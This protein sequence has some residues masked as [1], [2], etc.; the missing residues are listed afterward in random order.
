MQSVIVYWMKKQ[1]YNVKGKIGRI[2][3]QKIQGWAFIPD[4]NESLELSLVINEKIVLK[5]TANL[6]NRWTK[7]NNIHPT[8]YCGF[9]FSL[10][11]FVLTSQDNV[12]VFFKDYQ[13]RKPKAVTVQNYPERSSDNLYFFIH[14]PKTAGTTFRIMLEQQ[15]SKETFFPNK[16]DL[17]ANNGLYP[18][19]RKLLDEYGDKMATS[20][21][22]AGHYPFVVGRAFDRKVKFLTFLRPPVERTISNIYH[23]QRYNKRVKGCSFEEIIRQVPN[24]MDNLQTRFFCDKFSEPSAQFYIGKP[25]SR[26]QLEEAKENLKRCDF[27]GI[28]EA[29]EDSVDLLEK[30]FNWQLGKRLKKNVTPRKRKVLPKKLLEQITELNQLDIELYEYGKQLFRQRRQETK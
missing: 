17:K 3:R 14:I 11:N 9:V 22:I 18:Y 8:G 19:Y 26:N 1:H 25:L 12:Q 30:T 7:K 24:Q 13:L 29:F 5:K 15:F 4:S 10:K 16:E 2:T 21:V 23:L 27:I 6:F 28:T 20:A